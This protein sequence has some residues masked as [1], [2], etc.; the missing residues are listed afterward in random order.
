MEKGDGRIIPK[1]NK[2]P[3]LNEYK[4][5]VDILYKE[6]ERKDKIIEDLKEQNDVLFRTNIRTNEKILDLKKL[7]K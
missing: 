3:T 5:I 6:L 7:V 1:P 2:K 4:R